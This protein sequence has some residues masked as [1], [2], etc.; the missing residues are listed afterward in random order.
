MA[1]QRNQS[2]IA[3]LI[4]LTSAFPW[5]VGAGLALVSFVGLR[6]FSD[7]AQVTE[8]KPGYVGATALMAAARNLARMGQYVVP[9][10]FIIGAALSV[11]SSKK[12][13]KLLQDA[14]GSKGAAAIAGM[15]WREFEILIGEGFRRSG[16]S[17][18]D[19]GGKGPDGGIDLELRK[20]QEKFLVQCKHW[21]A[22]KVGVA[23]VRE[24]YG[25]MSAEGADGGVVVTSGAFTSEAKEFASGRNIRLMDGPRLQSLLKLASDDPKSVEHDSTVIAMRAIRP[26]CPRCDSEMVEREAKRGPQAG[27]K[28]LGCS[29]YPVCKGTRPF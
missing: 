18:T 27:A 16:Y 29:K 10:L 14:T 9:L 12:K 2:V 6:V 26:V 11:L 5:W 20:G 23:V 4:G 21:R 25:V 8:F 3:D 13:A 28:F 1:R 22:M 17:V 19:R 7:G 24:L 15:G